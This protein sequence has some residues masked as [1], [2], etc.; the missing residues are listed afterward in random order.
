MR[1]REDA[2]EALIARMRDYAR[3]A[4]R[5]PAEIGIEGR[6]YLAG[7]SAQ[8]WPAELAEWRALGTTHVQVYT[9]EGG[10]KSA[11]AHIDLLRRFKAAVESG[12]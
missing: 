7:R 1:R 8:Q 10:L 12:G 11:D 5:D 2:P 6:V 3:K 9:M 4:G